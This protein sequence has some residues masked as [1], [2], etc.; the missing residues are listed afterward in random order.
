MVMEIYKSA[1]RGDSPVRS[2][3]GRLVKDGLAKV[4]VMTKGDGWGAAQPAGTLDNGDWVY[5]AYLADGVTPATKD[6]SGCRNCH[7]PLKEYDYVA[8]YDQHFD[9]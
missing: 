3:D 6:F 7:A 4:F 2:A 1:K 9:K 8:R 5:A